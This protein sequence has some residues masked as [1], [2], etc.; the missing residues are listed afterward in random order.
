MGIENLAVDC[1]ICGGVIPKQVAETYTLHTDWGK[2][3]AY[4]HK[5]CYSDATKMILEKR[6]IE[7]ATEGQKDGQK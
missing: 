5:P 6:L 7:M 4:V 1:A 2:F 3:T